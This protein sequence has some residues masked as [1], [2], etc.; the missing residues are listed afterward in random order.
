RWIMFTDMAVVAYT[1]QGALDVVI[2]SLKT[3][4]TLP[5]TQVSLVAKDGEDLGTARTDASGRASFPHALLEGEGGAAP[6]MVMAYGAQGDLAVL[7][8][9]R[10][11]VDLSKQGVGGRTGAADEDTT[12]GRTAPQALDG[13]L[14]SDRGIY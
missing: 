3:A 5:N 9:D 7:D 11:P 10:S 1:G 13:F 12:A 6:K 8:L 4:K 2:R 14:Y